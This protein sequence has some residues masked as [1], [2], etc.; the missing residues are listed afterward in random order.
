MLIVFLFLNVMSIK[1]IPKALPKTSENSLN[2][3]EK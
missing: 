1:E 2:E 3:V